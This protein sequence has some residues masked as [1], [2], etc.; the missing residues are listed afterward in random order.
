MNR[1]RKFYI[2]GSKQESRFDYKMFYRAAT[3]FGNKL[4]SREM[5]IYQWYQ[6]QYEQGIINVSAALA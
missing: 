6:A 4:I 2:V 3:E 1:E 5:F